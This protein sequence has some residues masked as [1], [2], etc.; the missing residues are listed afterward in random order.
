MKVKV[1]FAG[2]FRR[3]VGEREADFEIPDGSTAGDLLVTLGKTYAA[4][5]PD[6]L[7]DQESLKFHRSMRLARVD[8]GT[9]DSDEMLFDGDELL[10]IFALAGG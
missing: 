4:C 5:L 6:G 9:I 2:L 10:V 7:W 3:Y 1:R 8:A